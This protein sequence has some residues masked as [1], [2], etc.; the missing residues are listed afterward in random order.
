VSLERRTA[1][2]TGAAQGLG[3]AIARALHARGASVVVADVNDDSAARVA[4]SLGER[5]RGAYVDVR[6]RASLER[7]LDDAGRV[8]VLVNNAARTLFT[9]LFEIDPDEWDD[10]LAT[11]LRGVFYGCQLAG[12]RMRE[13]G[14]GRILNMASIAGQAGGASGA[15]YAASKAGIVVLTKIVAAELAPHGVT[16]NALAPAAVRTPVFDELPEERLEA[17]RQR[18]PVGRFGEPAEIAEL[19]AFLCSEEAGYVTGATFDANGGLLMR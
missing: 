15:H 6:D 3:E 17:L 2:V 19:A 16:C 4:S 14:W 13:Q 1:V 7:M 11:N 5:A 10:V 12:P 8:D 9:P 18:I